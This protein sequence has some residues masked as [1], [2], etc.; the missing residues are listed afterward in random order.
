LDGLAAPSTERDTP[1]L[2]RGEEIERLKSWLAEVQ[3]DSAGRLV[4]V[5]GEA[6]VGKTAMLRHFCET[7]PAST[8]ILWGSCEGLLTPAPLGP[9]LD[10]AE[11]T[12]GELAELVES[13]GRPFEVA[14]A[15]LREAGA[16]RPTVVVFENVHW[17][18]GATLDVLRLLGGRVVAA[19]ALFLASYRDDELSPTHPLQI[20]LGEL[21]ANRLVERRKLKPLSA[22]AVARLAEPQDVDADELYRQTLGNPFFV[23][24]VLAAGEA[25]IPRTVRD[26]VLARSGRLAP[27]A[28]ALLE[29]VAVAPPQAELWLLERLA[30]DVLPNLDECLASGMLTEVAGGVAFRHELARLA[31]E[32]SLTPNRRAALHRQALAALESPPA[33]APDL[34]RVAHHAEAAGDAGAV[35]RS[36]SA[37][38]AL[39]ASLGA[40][41]EAAAQ[42]A[43]VLRFADTMN[44]EA[45]AEILERRSYECYL[46]GEVSE[47]LEEQE[48]ALE[49]Y[50]T[51]GDRLKEGDCLR[52]LSRLLRYVGRIDEAMEAGTQA[53]V[54]LEELP[55]G[56]EL[57][58]A[59][60]HVSHL[61]VWAEDADA[62]LAWSTRALELA[63]GL[64]DVE[65]SVYA[66]INLG[67]AEVLG[68]DL[69]SRGKFERSVELAREAGLEEHAGRGFVNL[70]WWAPRDRSYANADRYLDAGLDYCVEHGLDLWRLY[71]LAYRARAELDRGRWDEAAESAAL[72]ARDPRSSPVPRIWALTILGL[73]RAR[74]GD[75]DPWELLD[76]AWTLAEPTREPQRTDAVAAARAEA[77][78]LEGRPEGVAEATEA[79]LE[80]ALERNG[81]WIIGELA[82]WRRRAGVAENAPAGAA[83]P[84]ALQLAGEWTRAAELWRDIGCPYEAAL[85]LA[86]SDDETALRT[87]F[88][89]FEE[90]G[91][92]PAAAI[93]ARRLRGLGFRGVPRGPR[94]ATR[95][96]PAQLTARELEVLE[97]VADGLRNAEI[98]KRLFLSPRTVDHHV[99]AVLRKLGVR[100][101][102]EASAE[103]VRLGLARQGR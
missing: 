81:A 101:R 13:A 44:P 99:S 14:K 18:D 11:V 1:L 59:Y 97:L 60:C 94:P 21:A 76:E 52:S 87:A 84:Y 54:V 51:L 8:R 3:E 64:D 35:Q 98:A 40:H 55:P 50:R 31:V 71:L 28:R 41:R 57:A 85:A 26:A 72:V 68:G 90:L 82:C 95:A 83:E 16:R 10:I 34:A 58:M 46:T 33:G 67:A 39:A 80:L 91:A 48:R 65:A 96:N 32:E 56:H 43:R 53:V 23:T 73:V 102:A 63:E 62:A 103:A 5:A 92:G 15:L 69:S 24:E 100:T 20:V 17:A 86:D 2:E 37:A 27:P 47:A 66:L 9:L 78:W 19:P 61:F 30:A 89:E 79:T 74:R 36:A 22:G 77:A 88:H 4:F 70:V 45:R 29:A 38:G 49:L 12:G 6:G 42:Y 75:P 25:E 93:T 7:Q